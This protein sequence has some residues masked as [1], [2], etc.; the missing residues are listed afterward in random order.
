[1][2]LGLMPEEEYATARLE[3]RPGETLVLYTDGVTEAMRDAG[4]FFG[5]EAAAAALA[6]AGPGAGSQALVEA[7][8]ARLREFVAGARASDDVTV[9]AVQYRGPLTGTAAPASEAGS[10]GGCL[11]K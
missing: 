9:L 6:E 10:G 3:L 4:G 2:V 11:A 7:L 5:V 1:M 8:L